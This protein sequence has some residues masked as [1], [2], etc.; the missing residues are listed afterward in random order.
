[1]PLI[2]LFIIAKHPPSCLT[3]KNARLSIP[4]LPFHGNPL[5]PLEIV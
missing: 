3:N 4:E 1:M 5:M 2:I